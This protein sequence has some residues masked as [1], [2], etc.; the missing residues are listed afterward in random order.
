[1]SLGRTILRE[2]LRHAGRVHC[3]LLETIGNIN[4]FAN[5][6]SYNISIR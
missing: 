2:S 6:N 4:F 1:M 5:I 3:A